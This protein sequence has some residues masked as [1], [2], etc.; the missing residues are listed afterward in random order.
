VAPGLGGLGLLAVTALA[1][2]NFPTLAGSDAPAITLLPWLLAVAVI[3][4]LGLAAWLRRRRPDVYAGLAAL[5]V[6]AE[7]V[8]R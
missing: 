4:G 6:D 1:I 3:A 2:V 5:G 8:T 7:P